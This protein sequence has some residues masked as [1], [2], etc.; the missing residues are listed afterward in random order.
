MS[1]VKTVPTSVDGGAGPIVGVRVSFRPLISS[2]PTPHLDAVELRMEV[3]IVPGQPRQGLGQ[4]WSNERSQREIWVQPVESQWSQLAPFFQATPVPQELSGWLEKRWDGINPYC[5]PVDINQD[6]RA[7]GLACGIRGIP[8]RVRDLMA[9]MAV[10]NG[11]LA[12]DP[13]IQQATRSIQREISD[14]TQQASA[15]LL[16][17]DN[18][19]VASATT[20]LG[21]FEQNLAAMIFFI[22]LLLVRSPRYL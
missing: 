7:L 6:E 18:W 22:H 12:R 21:E 19:A 10:A 14:G 13:Q 11:A 8:E 5:P 15:S 2:T 1:Y 9:T 3:Q 16:L 17:A 4:F 20:D